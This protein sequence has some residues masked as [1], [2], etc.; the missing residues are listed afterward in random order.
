MRG[1]H[2]RP[3]VSCARRDRG[4]CMRTPGVHGAHQ[5][6][7]ESPDLSHWDSSGVGALEGG[8]SQ[9]WLTGTSRV[10]GPAAFGWS[11]NKGPGPPRAANSGHPMP[12]RWTLCPLQRDLEPLAPICAGPAQGPSR[13]TFRFEWFFLT[14]APKLHK[15]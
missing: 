10:W 11:E 7:A 1:L 9:T 2:W 4:W 3:L 13:G 8:L 15:L 5:L 12:S 6:D 14:K